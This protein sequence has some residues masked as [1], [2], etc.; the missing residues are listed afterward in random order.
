VG[1]INI[2]DSRIGMTE[3]DLQKTDRVGTID[4]TKYDHIYVMV[5][6]NISFGN[7]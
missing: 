2:D 7:L 3:E 6:V 4:K 1:N 5:K